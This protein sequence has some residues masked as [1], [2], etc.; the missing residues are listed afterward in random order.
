MVWYD[1]P[2][3]VDNMKKVEK[4]LLKTAKKSAEKTLRRDA[5]RTTCV[6]IYQPAVP[7]KLSKFKEKK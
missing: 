6:G 5:N 4:L 3:E 1:K 2:K 7:A